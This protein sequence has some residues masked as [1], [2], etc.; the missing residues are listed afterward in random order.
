VNEL[1]FP[2]AETPANH[3]EIL[4]DWSMAE[5]LSN[6]CISIRFSF[7]K[8]QKPGRKTI[9]AM[10][11]EG[12][13]SLPFQFRRKKGPSGRSIGPSHRHS[14]KSGRFIEDHYGIVFVK[15]DKLP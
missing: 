12:P 5:K 6:E 1:T 3:R 15:H 8:E 2:G 10:H 11:D 14:R 13:L 4:P 7:R 9:N